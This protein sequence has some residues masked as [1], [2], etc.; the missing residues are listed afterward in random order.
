MFCKN[1]IAQFVVV[2]QK[3]FCLYSYQKTVFYKIVCKDLDIK[4]CFLQQDLKKEINDWRDKNLSFKYKTKCCNM[5]IY[6]L[7]NK[8]QR[9]KTR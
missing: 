5:L 8:F 7:E 2:Q 3:H 1:M 9:I 6:N 4:D